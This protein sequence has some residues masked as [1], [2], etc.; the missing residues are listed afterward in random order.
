M[1]GLGL[2]LLIK[3]GLL[4]NMLAAITIMTFALVTA[5]VVA[6]LDRRRRSRRESKLSIR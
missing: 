4:E 6:F 5:I 2:L 3:P 1:L